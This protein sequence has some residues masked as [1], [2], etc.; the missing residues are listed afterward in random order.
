M[1]QMFLNGGGM[2]GGS[3]HHLLRGARLIAETSTA[4]R[5][6]LY[7]VGDRYPALQPTGTGG[8]AIAGEV[9]DL[10]LDVLRDSLLPA[11]PPELEL[12]VIELADGSASLGMILRGAF[13]PLEDLTDITEYGGWRAYLARL[14][15]AARHVEQVLRLQAHAP[16]PVGQQLS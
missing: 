13:P 8:R 14:V 1:S 5:Y 4:P 16:E 3:L 9:Y 10:P 7:S 15:T 2:R 11:E 6:R 12:G